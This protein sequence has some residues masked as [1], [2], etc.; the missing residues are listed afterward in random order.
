MSA[1]GTDD[2]DALQDEL[3][4]R[5]EIQEAADIFQRIEAYIQ[6]TGESVDVDE[7]D[8]FELENYI[9]RF[10]PFTREDL[11]EVVSGDVGDIL[12]ELR[13]SDQ[14]NYFQPGGSSGMGDNSFRS[15]KAKGIIH[16]T[17]ERP[18]IVV[19]RYFEESNI[20]LSLE[21]ERRGTSH[22]AHM[23]MK[24]N[25]EFYS[26][27]WDKA[28]NVLRYREPHGWQGKTNAEQ[29]MNDNLE[30]QDGEWTEK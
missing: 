23:V 24:D 8:D 2:L 3:K 27:N 10:G 14:V 17:D 15:F 30:W 5:Y 22:S 26:Q 19:N 9:D 18:E 13:P 20:E 6:E 11:D 25:S 1:F 21:K 16:S 7:I 4:E 12:R 29:Q 28:A